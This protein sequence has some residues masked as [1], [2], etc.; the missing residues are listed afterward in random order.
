[1]YIWFGRTVKQTHLNNTNSGG[2]KERKEVISLIK[3]QLSKKGKVCV[4]REIKPRSTYKDPRLQHPKLRNFSQQDFGLASDIL[5]SLGF[6]DL[7]PKYLFTS[8]LDVPFS[9]TL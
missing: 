6:E 7:L 5:H 4:S 8:N 3:L 1:V 2:W 9:F